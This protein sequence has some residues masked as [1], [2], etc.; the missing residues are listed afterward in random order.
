MPVVYSW[1][2]LLLLHDTHTHTLPLLPML[3]LMCISS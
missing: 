3:L 1:P 2:V